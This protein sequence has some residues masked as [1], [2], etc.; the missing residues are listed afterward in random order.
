MSY[1][2]R[3]INFI[4]NISLVAL[5][6]VGHPGA[7]EILYRAKIKFWNYFSRAPSADP[8]WPMTSNSCLKWTP[9]FIFYE[10]I[11]G[12]V[13]DDVIFVK[14]SI[15]KFR[16]GP[17]SELSPNW[18]FKWMIMLNDTTY[19]SFLP[20]FHPFFTISWNKSLKFSILTHNEFGGW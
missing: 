6:I 10:K 20:Y 16:S 11:P 17:F 12:Y 13:M 14:K 5:N 7:P 19:R 18:H 9:W 8:W 1:I 4:L 3:T 2:K 15:F